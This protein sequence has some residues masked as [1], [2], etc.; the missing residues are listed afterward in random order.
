D[1][2]IIAEI[3]NKWNTTKGNHKVAIYDDIASVLTTIGDKFT[4]YYVEVVPK[5]ATPYNKEFTP[6]DN[7]THSQRTANPKIRVIDGKSFYAMITGDKN[8]IFKIYDEIVV[9]LNKLNLNTD[10]DFKKLLTKAYG[11]PTQ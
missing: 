6:S 7:K 11:E 10:D 4:G 5:K 2:K 3:K 9:E 1:K 8:A